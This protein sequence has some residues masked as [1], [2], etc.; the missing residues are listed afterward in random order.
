MLYYWADLLKG[1]FYAN[2]VLDVPTT[3]AS[4]VKRYEKL[5][6]FAKSSDYYIYLGIIAIIHHDSH[7]A[8]I[9]T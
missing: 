5:Q 3:V 8:F 9:A 4:L 1:S 2:P 6:T 7:E